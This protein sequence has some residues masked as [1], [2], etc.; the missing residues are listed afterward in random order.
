MADEP[1]LFEEAQGAEPA[2]T[3]VE[4]PAKEST[5][6]AEGTPVYG[7]PIPIGGGE[8]RQGPLLGF[9]PAAAPE[10]KAEEEPFPP[11]PEGEPVGEPG[12]P[13]EGEGTPS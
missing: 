7:A 9:E 8:F 3:A 6:E 2:R 10:L 12:P 11:T 4:K 1:K 13:P 5:Q